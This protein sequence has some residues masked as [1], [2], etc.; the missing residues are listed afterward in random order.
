MTECVVDLFEAVEIEEHETQRRPFPE[1]PL[2]LGEEVASIENAGQLVARG[3]AVELANRG[4]EPSLPLHQPLGHRELLQKLSLDDGAAD[5]VV[6]PGAQ[7]ID[8]RVDSFLGRDHHRVSVRG[9]P[10][11]PDRPDQRVGIDPRHLRVDDEEIERGAV[12]R[13]GYVALFG[14]VGDYEAKSLK[15]IAD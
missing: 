11:A 6:E 9:S 10:A 13:R 5:G 7:C 4:L 2:R 15:E 14:G 3:Q 12:D 8:A 1:Q